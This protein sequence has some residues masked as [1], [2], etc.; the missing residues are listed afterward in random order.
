MMYKDEE[1]MG[2]LHGL[3]IPSVPDFCIEEKPLPPYESDELKVIE[4]AE[5]LKYTERLGKIS[6]AKSSFTS[7]AAG[8]LCSD[9]QECM[10]LEKEE[11]IKKMKDSFLS[12]VKYL[13]NKTKISPDK[14]ARLV[15]NRMYE[16]S[17]KKLKKAYPNFQTASEFMDWAHQDMIDISLIPLKDISTYKNNAKMGFVKHQDDTFNYF[18]LCKLIHNYTME[19]SSA[20]DNVY[21]MAA[22]FYGLSSTHNLDEKR[23]IEIKLD[24]RNPRLADNLRVAFSKN[25]KEF[26]ELRNNLLHNRPSFGLRSNHDEGTTI[27][28]AFEDYGKWREV[29][30]FEHLLGFYKHVAEGTCKTLQYM[31]KPKK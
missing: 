19:L 24:S 28:L 27:F 21:Y 11:E 9:C 12:D 8:L 10:Y 15:I 3:S 20:V 7:R 31:L 14:A 1:L 22:N 23:N 17:C 26:R 2:L 25:F 6:L 18:R 4:E 16:D 29:D 5:R 13:I 30:L